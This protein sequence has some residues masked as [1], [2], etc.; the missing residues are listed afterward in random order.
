MSRKPSNFFIKIQAPTME[1]VL[2]VKD[3]VEEAYI[4]SKTRLL[5]SDFG[6]Y[7]MYIDLLRRRENG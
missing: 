5:K 6:G 7:H 2:E 3:V 4:V 1:R